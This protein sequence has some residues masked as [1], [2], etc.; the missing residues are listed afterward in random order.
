MIKKK[1][2]L[3]LHF[4]ILARRREKK[5]KSIGSQSQLYR[6]YVWHHQKEHDENLQHL[7]R[8]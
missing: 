1:N 3:N 2:K 5:K 8:K 6:V 4:Y 7:H